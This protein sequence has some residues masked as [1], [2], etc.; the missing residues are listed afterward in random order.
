MYNHLKNNDKIMKK[1]Y[2][3]PAIELLKV[4]AESICAASPELDVKEG[5]ANPSLPNLIKGDLE[6]DAESVL[7]LPDMLKL[8]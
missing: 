5:D 8:W 4:E 2:M 3:T 1:I 7:G 6:T